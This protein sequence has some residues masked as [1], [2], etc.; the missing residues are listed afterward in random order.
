MSSVKVNGEEN[1]V[2][3]KETDQPAPIDSYGI[4]KL[5]AEKKVQRIAA[6][7]G[8]SSVILRPPL[9]YG[10]GVSANFLALMKFVDKGRLIPLGGV[11]NR[12]SLIYLENLVHAVMT[13]IEHPDAGGKTYFVSDDH[14][15]S[16]P[17]LIR[18]IGTS[19]NRK[20]KLLPMPEILLFIFGR[21]V[22]KGASIDRLIGSLTVDIS[23][24]KQELGWQPP[25]TVTHGL[26]K[27]IEWYKDSRV[28]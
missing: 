6:E 5:M 22:G 2:S 11:R 12:R 9:V 24:I 18:M 3:Y 17:E 16:T 27:T 25:Y 21:L 7:T 23:K 20:V 28:N 10:P 1:A 4:S 14:D 13:C 8:M 26:Q 15:V 19:L